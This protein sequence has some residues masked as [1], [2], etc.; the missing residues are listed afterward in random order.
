MCVAERGREISVVIFGTR[1]HNCSTS[2]YEVFHMSHV[3]A[4]V[5]AVSVFTLL[6]LGTSMNMLTL[7]TK[8]TG[9]I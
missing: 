5:S 7:W 6:K 3:L 9:Y 2:S 8:N 1:V 4:I